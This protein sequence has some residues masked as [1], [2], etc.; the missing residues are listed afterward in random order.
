MII[1]YYLSFKLKYIIKYEPLDRTPV[2]FAVEVIEA[3]AKNVPHNKICLFH[4]KAKSIFPLMQIAQALK[5]N[6]K[7]YHTMYM[8]YSFKIKPKNIQW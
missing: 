5:S 1:L 2:L 3:L 8:V 4:K 7:I 6:F